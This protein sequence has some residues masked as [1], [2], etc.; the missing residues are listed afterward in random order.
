M[1]LTV[2]GDAAGGV[3]RPGS[4]GSGFLLSDDGTTLLLD[5]GNGVLGNLRRVASFA[6]L[7]AV[8][9]T[10]LHLDHVADVLPLLGRAYTVGTI[11]LYAPPGGEVVLEAF[12]RLFSSHVDALRS[13]LDFR[14]MVDPVEIGRL[15]LTFPRLEHEC[16]PP[17]H[18]VV[19]EG[20]KAK[21][22][23]LSDTRSFDGMDEIARN[24]DLVLAAASFQEP[25]PAN[26]RLLRAHM[27][28]R[29][30]GLVARA[31]GAKALLLTHIHDL[32]DPEASRAEA[33]AVSDCPVAVARP[34]LEQRI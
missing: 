16:H 12:I 34:L 19:V 20:E 1:K 5:C 11:P 24:A 27:T 26:P 6:D 32:L 23:Y 17:C 33:A 31:A 4:A 15:R 18:A 8:V 21:F 10:H 30:A 9:L 13:V 7:D 14:P 28:A 2:L 25:G 3:P 22:V 29:Q